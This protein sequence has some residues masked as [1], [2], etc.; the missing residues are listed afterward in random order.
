MRIES[1]GISS[2]AGSSGGAESVVRGEGSRPAAAMDGV[3]LSPRARM[4]AIA[5]QALAETPPV[6]RS[7]VE[8]AR[9]RLRAGQYR[10]DGRSI[11]EALLAAIREGM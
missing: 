7:V 2:V 9:A 5:R 11:A 8:D 4:M 3:E 6:R 10:T 1:S